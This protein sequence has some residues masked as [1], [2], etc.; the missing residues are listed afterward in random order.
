MS[1]PVSHEC[2]HG[3][4]LGKQKRRDEREDDCC[5]CGSEDELSQAWINIEAIFS[6][7]VLKMMKPQSFGIQGW[8]EKGGAAIMKYLLRSSRACPQMRGHNADMW[9]NHMAIASEE[10]I[11]GIEFNRREKIR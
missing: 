9:T 10:N 7:R 8:R 11:S 3:K 2:H 4:G 1:G 5:C 6:L